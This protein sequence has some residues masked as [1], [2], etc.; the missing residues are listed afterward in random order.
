MASSYFFADIDAFHLALRASAAV[1]SSAVG[2]LG[3][4]GSEE[5]PEDGVLS[6][7][8]VFKKTSKISGR[9]AGFTESLVLSDSSVGSTPKASPIH[10]TRHL[11]STL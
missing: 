6:L 10:W 11:S 9:V 7:S 1:L 4:S 2:P 3:F 8:R 5:E